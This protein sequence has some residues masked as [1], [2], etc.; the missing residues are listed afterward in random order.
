MNKVKIFL[1]ILIFGLSFL[2]MFLSAK[3]E[4]ATTDESVHLFAGYTYLTQKDFRLDPEHPPL[5]KEITALPLLII[6]P[7]YHLN[8]DWNTA[9]NYYFDSWKEARALG[10]SFLYLWENDVFKLLLSARIMMMILTLFLGAAVY[11][12]T[13]KIYN[14]KT[15]IFATALTLFL[16]IVL[17]HGRLVNTDIGVTLFGLLTIYFWS[18]YLKK[19]ILINLLFSAT[20]LGLALSSKYTAIIFLPI[21]IILAIVKLFLDRKFSNCGKHLLAF[22]GTLIVGFVIIWATYGF[23]LKPAPA[24]NGGISNELNA[25]S[26]ITITSKYNQLYEN[27]RLILIPA[28]FFKGLSLI[29]RHVVGGNGAFLLGNNSIDGWWYYFPVAIFFKTPIALFILIIIAALNIKKNKSDDIFDEYV[30]ILTPLLFLLFALLSRA[31]LGVRH[32]LPIYPFLII[33]AAKTINLVNIKNI[34]LY[35]N[36]ITT[37]VILIA[38]FWYFTVSIGAYPNYLAYFNEFS[39]GSN[40]GY[41]LLSDSNLDWGQDILRI[42]NYLNENNI[43]KPYLV[44]PWDGDDALKYYGIDFIPLTPDMQNIKGPAVVSATYYDTDA[45]SWLRKYPKTNITAG[46]FLV[47]LK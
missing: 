41:K 3:G 34:K 9:G 31:N 40:N 43:L 12:Y 6:K 5:I 42:K 13:K 17:A 10:N 45:Y 19:S 21:M 11:F 15:A 25:W 47:E 32:I 29:G 26:T 28:D 23:P 20:F 33:F 27:V 7:N 46:V 18:A 24:P 38:S 37:F 39:G 14:E 4:S 35:K 22:L 2:L 44:Y 1:L 36:S 30:L 8:N 16:P